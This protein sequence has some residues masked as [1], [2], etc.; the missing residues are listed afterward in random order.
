MAQNYN[1]NIKLTEIQHRTKKILLLKVSK[2]KHHKQHFTS[3]RI[4]HF[5]E[6]LTKKTGSFKRACG[7]SIATRR[8]ELHQLTFSRRS[9]E[10]YFL[11]PLSLLPS[12]FRGLFY[13]L[14]S[15]SFRSPLFF[16][17]FFFVWVPRGSGDELRNVV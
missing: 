17:I 10:S 11:S 4:F 6:N 16:S 2:L 14:P 8:S 5:R 13:F 1:D 15:L 12:L 3:S 7:C 9:E